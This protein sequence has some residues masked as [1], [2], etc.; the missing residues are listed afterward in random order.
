MS[1]LKDLLLVTPDPRIGSVV[2]AALGLKGHTAAD[3]TCP[4][5]P[6]LRVRL[7][8]MPTASV[9]VDIDPDPGAILAALDQFSRQFHDARFIILA[10]AFQGEL[11]LEAMRA[12]ARQF[13]LK[14]SIAAEL[15]P[16][17]ERLAPAG[18]GK[19]QARGTVVTVLSAGGG[20][21]ATTIAVN[22]ANEL[23]LAAGKPALVVDMDPHYG[24]VAAY[25]G[26]Q[27]RY[28]IADLL[29]RSGQIDPDLVASTALAYSD[30]LHALISPPGMTLIESDPSAGERLMEMI[31]AAQRAYVYTVIDA[32][33]VSTELAVQLAQVS[34]FTF[35]VFQL[36]VK[37]I[38]VARRLHAA[39]AESGVSAGQLIQLVSRYR[40]KHAM[41]TL[42][43][44]AKAIGGTAPVCV[45][46][47]FRSA[48]ES[49]NYGQ[50]LAQAAPRSAP[51]S[52]ICELAKRIIKSQTGDVPNAKGK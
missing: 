37:D 14:A 40:A 23:Q 22:L 19:S 41:V 45:R 3:M 34:Q 6:S 51:R 27:G 26:L 8:Q 50:P 20:C 17:L 21:G 33:R 48:I 25:L 28:G 5:M 44:A 12:G 24:A 13:I 47:D 46:N 18:P 35:I 10:G 43:E 49:I 31:D 15:S 7:E 4:D 38:K 52:E 11:V 9:L 2:G 30:G 16:A 42:E 39:L 29:A 32:P 36:A 1:A